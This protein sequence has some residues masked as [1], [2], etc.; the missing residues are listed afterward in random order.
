MSEN[1]IIEQRQVI[2]QDRTA[3]RP[4]S[5]LEML[6]AANVEPALRAMLSSMERL[7]ERARL[8]L[9]RD[10]S[11]LAAGRGLEMWLERSACL[12]L[13][14]DKLKATSREGQL[15]LGVL[16]GVPTGEIETVILSRG[17]FGGHC[18]LRAAGLCEE[19][20]AVTMQLA[21][22]RFEPKLADL[23]EAFGLTPSE[24]HVVEMLQQGLGANE[25]GEKLGIS[26]HTVRAHLRHCYDK[27]EV[28]S[29]EELWQKLAP[30]RLN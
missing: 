25:I 13:S 11:V 21:E 2:K 12:S 20:L 14:D 29:R 18:I 26:V 24:M 22:K 28:S 23:Q 3:V 4:L 7:D 8:V 9:E 10:G 27:L 16:L 15:K 17:Q 1:G 19:A 30:Y 5:R 6:T